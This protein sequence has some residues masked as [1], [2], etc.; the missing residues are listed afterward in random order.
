MGSDKLPFGHFTLWVKNHPTVCKGLKQPTP[1]VGSDKL[2]FGHFKFWVNTHP[3]VC[4]GLRQPTPFVGSDKLPFVTLSCGEKSPDRH[5]KG[6]DINNHATSS[7]L[8]AFSKGISEDK[9]ATLIL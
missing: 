5:G 3:T 9:Q 2:P 1:F 4:K 7:F 6:Y 8:I